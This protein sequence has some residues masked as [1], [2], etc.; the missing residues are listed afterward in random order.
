M[1]PLSNAATTTICSLLPVWGQPMAP[2]PNTAPFAIWLLALLSSLSSNNGSCQ[3][4]FCCKRVLIDHGPFQ[5]ARKSAWGWTIRPHRSVSTLC[6]R[7]ACVRACMYCASVVCA[8]CVRRACLPALCVRHAW[9]RV[10]C[11][12]VMRAFC[13][14]RA[15]LCNV[16]ALRGSRT[17]VC[18]V[19]ACALCM[20]VH[21]ACVCIVR[22]LC[23][24]ALSM[25]VHCAFRCVEH[26]VC[27]VRSGALSMRVHC[28]CVVCA[29]VLFLG[30]LNTLG[31]LALRR[32]S[33][34]LCLFDNIFTTDPCFPHHKPIS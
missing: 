19:R 21:C 18:I 34:V 9:V 10:G 6:V 16:R 25:R 20:R 1:A 15:F 27:I 14:R 33:P 17:C 23:V 8:M 30:T 28:A 7:R 3:P 11:A 22:A 12:S 5:G 29:C 31:T 26:V 24:C 13:N 4:A 2:L 32:L